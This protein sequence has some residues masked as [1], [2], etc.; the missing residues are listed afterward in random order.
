[1]STPFETKVKQSPFLSFLPLLRSLRKERASQNPAGRKEDRFLRLHHSDPCSVP[2]PLHPTPIY[3]L[4]FHLHGRGF[5]VP[6]WSDTSE[7]AKFRSWKRWQKSKCSPTVQGQRL[8]KRNWR[9]SMIR[10][11]ALFVNGDSQKF[12]LRRNRE[13]ELRGYKRT[14]C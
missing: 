6:H 13:N 10:A 8:E 3:P 5:H 9:R 12:R 14:R 1:M 4:K 11:F 2:L 7:S